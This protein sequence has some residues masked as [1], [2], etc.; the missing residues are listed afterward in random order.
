MA[1]NILKDSKIFQKLYTTKTVVNSYLFY[2]SFDAWKHGDYNLKTFFNG[3]YR[4]EIHPFMISD[5]TVPHAK[6]QKR[7]TSYGA[8]PYSYA[9]LQDEQDN[10][11]KITM[12][13]NSF[14]TVAR[15]IAQLESRTMN[16]GNNNGYYISPSQ[17][18]LPNIVVYIMNTQHFTI[19]KYTMV[20][21]YFV[22]GE[23]LSLSY[24]NNDTIKYSLRFHSDVIRYEQTDANDTVYYEEYIYDRTRYGDDD[25]AYL[26][27]TEIKNAQPKRRFP[28]P[29][30]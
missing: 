16:Y 25:F 3:E 6:W 24:E 4:R 13:E 2:V 11:M 21:P 9:V 19:S 28:I 12:E 1:D 30:I 29:F 10:E 17:M 27:N 22:G 23:E 7:S 8:V 18:R 5:V 14:G 26:K 20:S 15:F